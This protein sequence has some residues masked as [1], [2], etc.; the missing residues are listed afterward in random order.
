MNRH[1]EFLLSSAYDR[2]DL[3]PEHLADLRKSG[4]SD[5]TIRD[6]KIR[7]VPPLDMIDALLGYRAPN[8]KSAYLTPFPNPLG[9]WLDY[10]KLKVFAFDDVMTEVRADHIDEYRDRRRY[11]GG[12]RKYLVQRAS[13]PRLYFPIPTMARALEGAETLWIVEGMKKALALMQLALPAIGIE[14]AWSW[15]LKGSRGLLPDFDQ[16]R[17]KGRGVKVVPD[18]DINTE[19]MIARAYYGFVGA[20]HRRG[21]HVQLVMLPP[22]PTPEVAA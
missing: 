15:H 22:V 20:L 11:N 21:A 2:R 16:V 10:V 12:R 1:L 4:L 3:H 8:V 19:P 6:H 17:L 9:G 5:E 7:T 18:G 13:A 14:S